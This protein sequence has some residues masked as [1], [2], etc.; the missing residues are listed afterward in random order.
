VTDNGPGVPPEF[1]KDGLF[2]RFRTT[3][4]KGLGIGLYHCKAIVEAHEGT[5]EAESVAG[6]GTTFTIH[7]PVFVPAPRIPHVS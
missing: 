6:G 3:K 1:L 4:K 5:I 7:L 2:K